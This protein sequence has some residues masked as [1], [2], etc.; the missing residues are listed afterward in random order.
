MNR[1][2]AKGLYRRRAV[3]AQTIEALETRRAGLATGLGVQFIGQRGEQ[4]RDWSE[5]QPLLL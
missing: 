4:E 2:G 5:A 1:A 3:F